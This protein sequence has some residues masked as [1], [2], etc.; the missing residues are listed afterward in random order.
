[1]KRA[2]V[3][4]QQSVYKL[5]VLDASLVGY[6]HAVETLRFELVVDN[7]LKDTE[8][9]EKAAFDDLIDVFHFAIKPNEAGNTEYHQNGV[10]SQSFS[11]VEKPAGL[12]EHTFNHCA[13]I[14]VLQSVTNSES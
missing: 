7:R 2:Y 12:H 10:H 3:L 6:H 13:K 14:E 5:D 4:R 9:E 1:M 8:N 11:S